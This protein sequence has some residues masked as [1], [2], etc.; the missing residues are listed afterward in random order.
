LVTIV[1]SVLAIWLGD[2]KG[3]VIAG[4]LVAICG[5]YCG[6]TAYEDG[7]AKRAAL[8]AAG[9]AVDAA[10]RLLVAQRQSAAKKQEPKT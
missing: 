10:E 9:A 1:G 5:I 8:K 2:D 7:Q 4:A 6:G 3:Y